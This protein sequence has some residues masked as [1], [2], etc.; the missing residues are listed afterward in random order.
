MLA[1]ETQQP[2]VVDVQ[3]IDIEL[4]QLWEMMTLSKAIERMSTALTGAG[5][6]CLTW[7]IV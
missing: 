5:K 6:D 7:K 2:H 1:D 4:L 3:A